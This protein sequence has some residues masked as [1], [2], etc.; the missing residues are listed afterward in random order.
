MAVARHALLPVLFAACIA[1]AAVANSYHL[2]LVSIIALTAIVGVGLNILL[3]LSG[4]V[5][6]GHVGFFA[7][8]AYT[9]AI[10]TTAVQWNFWPALALAVALAAAV[11]VLLGLVTLRVSGPYLAMVT[12]AFGFVVEYGA[13]EWKS[14]TGGANGMMNIPEPSLLGLE[15]TGRGIA[16]TSVALAALA[17]AGYQ[18]LARSGWGL[19]M[20]AVRDSEVAA[21]SVG[22]DPLVPRTAAFM[23][24]AALAGLAGALFAPLAEFIAPSSFPFFQS[25]LF[26]LVVMIGGAERTYGPLLGA[27]IVVLLPELLAGLA[28]YRVLLF[29]TLLLIVLWIAPAGVVGL[30][31]QLMR[32]REDDLAPETEIPATFAGQPAPLTVRALSVSFGGVQAVSDVGF[33]AEPA[34]ITSIVGPNGAGKTT[35]LNVIA[36]FYRPAFG[37]VA[38]QGK[39]LAGLPAHAVARAGI[40]RTFQTSQLFDHMTV[41]ENLL[42]AMQDGRLGHPLRGIG[43]GRDSHHLRRAHGLLRFVGFRGDPRTPAARLPHIDRRLVEIARALAMQPRVLLLD[44]P[45]AGLGPQDTHK[46]GSLLQQ[47]AATGMAV[48][49]VE[50]DMGLV[51]RI[52]DQVVV[53]DAGRCIARGAPDKVRADPAVARAYL[54]AEVVAAR[55]RAAARV[56]A[57]DRVLGVAQLSAGYGAARVL[58]NVSLEV[59]R[60]ELVAVLGANGAGK[61]TLM[62]ALAGLLRPVSGQILFAGRDVAAIDAHRLAR[63][64]LVLVPEGRQVFPELTV[65]DNLRLGAY[66]R[67]DFE[68]DEIDAALARFPAL[69]RRATSRAGLLSGGE[70]QMLAIARGLLARPRVLLLDEPSLGLAPAIVGELFELIA[71]LRDEGMSILLV[72]QMAPLALAVADRAY[73]IDRGRI[74]RSASAASLKED[75]MLVQTYLG[76]A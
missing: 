30:V 73:V 36:G 32:A 8:G 3:G 19:A 5:S 70:Q 10:L 65:I 53:L 28:E 61:S 41:I 24:S 37:S 64:G 38:L 6:F 39:E 16:F 71:R 48:V 45:V 55:P 67:R 58:D 54:G 12:I 56:A 26:V 27:L 7:L 1:Y 76:A 15:W 66:A 51:M 69:S 40:A 17:L 33:E 72:D 35:V 62:R 52:S 42:A 50:H 31:E 9:T 29:A 63:D 11:G 14:V 60:G 46:L 75:A 49:L 47:I 43:L 2:Y 44:E 57:A 21:S 22:V 34:R 13:V 4:Q 68:V 25:I 74:V 23:L 18:R 20:R 59:N